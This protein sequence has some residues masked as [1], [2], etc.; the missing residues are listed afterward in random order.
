MINRSQN[1]S[2]PLSILLW[3]ANGLIHQINEIKAFLSQTD[4]DILLISESHLTNNSCCKIPG[5]TTYQCNHPDGTSHAGSA[6]L[7]K[8]NIKHTILPTYQTNTIQATNIALTLNNIPTTISSAYFP[9]Q[10][11]LSTLDLRQYFNSLGHTFIAGG[12][13]N[14]KHPSWGSRQTNTR[15]RVLNNYIINNKLKI[16]SPKNPT[17][18]PSHTNRLPDILDFFITTLP[19]HVKFQI[20]DSLDLSSDHTP[21]ILILNDTSYTTKSYP[22]LT[23]GKTNWSTFRNILDNT[24]NLNTSLKT[25]TDIESTVLTLTSLIQKAAIDSSTKT[26]DIQITTKVIP[27]HI[28][29]LICEKRRARA[30]W[31]RTHLPSDKRIYN[32]LTTSLKN[33]LRKFNSNKFHDYLNS[34][35]NA[36]N[37]LWKATKN[38]LREKTKIAPLRYPDNSLAISNLDKANLFATDLENRFTPHPDIQNRD[39]ML[40]VESLLNQ[41]LPMSLPTNHTSPSEILHIINKLHNNKAPGHDLI[42]NRIIKNLPK[43]SIIFLTFIFNSILRLSYIPPSWKH[44]IIIL[45]HKPGKPENLPSSF[46]PISLLPSFSKILEKIILKRIY[47]IINVQN[48]I[49]N[50]QFGFRNKHSALHQVHRIVDNIASSLER[51]YFCSAVFLDVAQAFDRVWHKGLL[52]KTRFLPAPLYLIINS[53][54]S[55]RTF[56]VRCDDVL[57]ETHSAK[58]GVPQGSILAPTLYNIYTSDI[59]QSHLTSL[60]TFADDT[61]IISSDPDIITSTENL[62]SHL[63]DLQNWFNLWRIKINENKSSHITFTLRPNTS[64]SV[65]LNNETIPRES[66][67]K[68]LGIHL[69]QRLTWATHIKTKRK[70]M[71]IKLHKLRQLL[72][73]KISL[74]DKT[75]VYKQLIRPALTYGIEFWGSTKTSNLNLLQSFQ[76]ISLR[77]MTNAPWYV[78]NLTIHKDLNIPT[79]LTL[80]STHYKK[81][82]SKTNNHPNPLI[83]NLSSKTLPDNPPR[84]LKRNWPRDLLR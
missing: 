33:T 26:S 56:Q 31:Q 70:S 46:R 45:I 18:W 74:S 4:I 11:K 6:I 15:G 71:K 80:A 42:T 13:F 16:I 75:L 78:S 59:P 5:Y 76:S 79:L 24:I 34:I 77:L 25:P 68:Y 43:K 54:L 40:H 41:T 44:S 29:Q 72:R 83:S 67:V 1:I 49:P 52:Y 64:P 7:L 21:V 36:D 57:S 55:N 8:S 62:Q 2:H 27:Q 38:I 58:A 82:H 60:A 84:R 66:S 51:K 20:F 35:K 3:N 22:T 32:N 39:H 73:S 69:D 17:Y 61:C 28:S 14:S 10:Q 63:N 30:K 47:P 23:P 53:F 48:T 12:D 9:P 37:S 50:T 65:T 19:N 81:L